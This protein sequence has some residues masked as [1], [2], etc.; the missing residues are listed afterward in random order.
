MAKNHFCVVLMGVRRL[1]VKEGKDVF[2]KIWFTTLVEKGK[3]RSKIL[4][5]KTA[6]KTINK[7]KIGKI[8]CRGQTSTLGTI[9]QNA[10]IGKMAQIYEIFRLPSSNSSVN[11]IHPPSFSAVVVH[12]LK[13]KTSL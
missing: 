2:T 12:H 9:F 5:S 1:F 7:V 3:N 4:K 11:P 10:Y 8:R 13:I 6:F